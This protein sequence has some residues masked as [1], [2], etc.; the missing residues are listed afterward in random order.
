VINWIY[1]PKFIQND[2][3][4][5]GHVLNGWQLSAITT[6]ASA[7]PVTPTINSVSTSSNGVWTG[8]AL[9]NNTINGSGGWNRVPWLPVG[10]L[11]VDQIYKV[12]ARLTRSFKLAEKVKLNLAF[13]AFNSFNT[14][15]NTS[16][17]TAAYAV[18]SG[19]IVK[20]VLTNGVSLLGTGT[21]SQG[22]PDGTNA[23]RAQLAMRVIF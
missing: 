2:S 13:E 8:I 7:H 16:V 14:I 18:S 23:R 15:N 5:A 12:D 10:Y 22:F 9:A 11:D 21:A 3:S 20:P 19:G 4:L 1:A 6:M 17:Q